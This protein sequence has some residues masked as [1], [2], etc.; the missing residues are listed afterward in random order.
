MNP[1]PPTGA[2][3]RGDVLITG[4]TGFLGMELLARLL[5]DGDRR[6]WALVRSRSQEE[7]ELRVRD[8][9]ASLVPD[10]ESV[11][12]RVVP[13][14]GDLMR[15]GLGLEPRRRDELA[16]AVGEVI[17]SAASVSFSLPLDQARAVNVEGTRRMLELA[18]LASAR[19]GGLHRFA[20]VS[21]AYVAGTHRGSFGERDLARGQGF[22]NTYERSKWE[23]ERLVRRYSE[24]LPAQVFRPSI[25]VGDER[26]GWTASFN[27]I[28]TPLRAY[29]RGALPALPARRSAPVD[30]VPVSHVAR[31]I[32]A[33]ADAGA[34]RTWH[35]AAGPAASTVGELIDRAGDLLG[36]P[37]ARALPPVVYR[38]AVHPLLLRRAGPAQRRWLERGEV[39]FPYFSTRTRFDTSAT[40][41][42]LDGAGVAPAPPLTSYL[43]RLLDF[44]ER[45]AWGRR[46]VP[47]STVTS[48]G[49]GGVDEREVDSGTDPGSARPHR[50]GHRRKQRARARRRARARTEGRDGGARV[51][52]PREG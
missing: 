19:G 10:P 5:G 18:M 3:T 47:R 27:V 8:T 35:L 28:Y 32:L 33:L 25:V 21:T 1:P 44:A 23:A 39:F 51:P 46:P 2:R 13:L 4:A 6:V 38:R 9:L 29:A 24:L 31:A 42:A 48:P 34:G 20:H 15:D 43:H 52:Q 36:R 41:A 11:A 22:N 7:A 26:T 45:A 49:G 17:H 37:R 16:E 30:A 40:R 50:P 14:A 12:G